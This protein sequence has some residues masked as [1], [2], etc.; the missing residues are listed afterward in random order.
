MKSDIWGQA[1]NR[2]PGQH[3]KGLGRSH[4]NVCAPRRRHGTAVG[5]AGWW[6]HYC[7]A[8]GGDISARSTPPSWESSRKLVVLGSG[9]V[10]SLIPEAHRVVRPIAE[11]L[12]WDFNQESAAS[13]VADLSDKGFSASIEND[14]EAGVR[15]HAEDARG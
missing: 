10:A 6:R 13:M 2:I 8:D 12:V 1:R 3:G 9:R 11:V 7:A 15:I 5:Y 4:V 14:L